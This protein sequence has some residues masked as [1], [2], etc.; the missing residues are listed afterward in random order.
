MHNHESN[1]TNFIYSAIIFLLLLFAYAGNLQ[2]LWSKWME[3]PD[4]SHG[5]LIPL[6][7]LF[8][9]FQ[10]RDEIKNI[11]YDGSNKGLYILFAAV[12][13]FI[14]SFRAQINFIL[15]YSMIL[16]LLGLV[17]FLYGKVMAS[18][19]AFPILYL[20]YMVPFWGAAINKLGNGLK[21]LSSILTFKIISIFGFPVF[22][23][24]VILQLT[25]GSLEVADPC[26]GIRSLMALLALGTVVAYYSDVNIVKKV[27]IVLLAIPLAFVG[28]TFR[29]VFFALVLQIK[30]V[31]ITE[32]PLHTIS[33]IGIFAFALI[34][35]F[36]FSKWVKRL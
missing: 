22:R 5:P 8:L 31:L 28:N 12:I 15:S 33:G 14:I 4:Y 2:W 32:G 25:N 10:K 6:I 19:L 3:N 26:S 24:G 20:V 11:K 36:G 18:A 16:F 34:F 30:G 29:V 21:L 13:F 27:A 17:L 35:L 7:S 1:I 9:F 23:D